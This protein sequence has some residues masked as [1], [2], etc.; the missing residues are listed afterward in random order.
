MLGAWSSR[1][2]VWIA[3]GVALVGVG[4]VALFVDIS[5]RVEGDFFFSEHD[6]QMQAT[7]SVGVAAIVTGD[8][9]AR[10]RYL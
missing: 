1:A 7:D 8:V 4:L 3:I 2:A 5:P 9:A 10:V 6:P